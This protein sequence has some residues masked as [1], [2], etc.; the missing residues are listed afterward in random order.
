MN[1]SYK[2]ELRTDEDGVEIMERWNDGLT[3]LELLGICNLISQEVMQQLKG[4]IEP[5]VIKRNYIEK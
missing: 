5:D 1:K 4:E 3:A 2:I